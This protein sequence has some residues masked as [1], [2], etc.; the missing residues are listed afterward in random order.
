MK[1]LCHNEAYKHNQ[2]IFV[3][4]NW[5]TIVAILRPIWRPEAVL[6][7]SKLKYIIML[8]SNPILV[9]QLI[10]I[11]QKVQKTEKKDSPQHPCT[12]Q[13]YNSSPSGWVWMKFLPR[14]MEKFIPRVMEKKILT[15]WDG[16][17]F[18]PL[19]AFGHLGKNF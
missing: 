7:N 3:L 2:H 9:Y 4:S 13:E 8:W 12:S 6:C 1:D 10:L 14:V 17:I 15:S 19:V 16:K 18:L 5:L 11:H